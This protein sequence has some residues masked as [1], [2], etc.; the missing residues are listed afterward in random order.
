[1][2]HNAP[3]RFKT[4]SPEGPD[5]MLSR[6]TDGAILSGF[7]LCG[8]EAKGQHGKRGVNGFPRLSPPTK[9]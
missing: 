5:R 4:G 9:V 7:S 1:M 8:A 6:F 2:A 3:L